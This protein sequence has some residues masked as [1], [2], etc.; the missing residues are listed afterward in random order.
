MWRWI[1]LLGAVCLASVSAQTVVVLPFS[2]HSSSSN[3]DWIGESVAEC[4]RETLFSEG[5]LV[6]DRDSRSEGFRRLSLRPFAPLTRAS[7]VKLAEV[8]DAERVVYG[9]FQV[10]P[11]GE[12]SRLQLSVRVMDLGEMRQS[13]EDSADGPLEDLTEVQDR[14]AWLALRRLTDPEKTPTEVQ[15]RGRRKPV[16][17]DALEGYIRGLLAT[18]PEQKHRLFTQAARIDEGFSQPRFQLGRLLYGSKEYKVAAGWFERV[19]PEN[20]NYMEASF[21]L[22]LCRYEMGVYDKAVVAFRTVADAV[23][24]NEVWNDLGAAQ[25]RRNL[26]EAAES[27]RKAI[28]GD[29]GDPIYHFNLGYALWKR[30]EFEAA[31]QSFRAALDLA[32]DDA[33]A[34][35]ML[36]RCLKK[37]P[38]EQTELRIKGL[39]R[40]KYNFEEMA[41]RQLRASLQKKIN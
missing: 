13:P 6:L 33:E 2:N 34:T 31:A 1:L 29:P 22:G 24:L 12:K 25:S 37:T 40:L 38:V 20:P 11:D 4:V 27:F 30:A 10:S 35:L 32:P 21:L 26:P 16:R 3:L 14:L 9:W 36:G 23:P 18:A 28:E 8:L 15:L 5:V 19:P 17:L 7:V 39:E 41:Y